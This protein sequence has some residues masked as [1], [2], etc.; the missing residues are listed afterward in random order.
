M[1]R[2]GAS[3]A[4]AAMLLALVYG[5]LFHV[6]E[7]D[8]HDT[9]A[10]T[11]HAHFPEVGQESASA[12]YPEMECPHSHA[13]VRWL[14]VLTL[15][16]PITVSFHVVVDRTEPVPVPSEDANQI[17]QPVETLHLH[18]PPVLSYF[19]LRSPPSLQLRFI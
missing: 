1:Q 10:L 6:H 4:V 14:D 11:I 9:S 15:N 18:S 12:D 13:H 7:R 2:F 17:V 5:P 16:K 19:A 8:D 3:L